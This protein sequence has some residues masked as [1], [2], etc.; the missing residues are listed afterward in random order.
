MYKNETDKPP[1]AKMGTKPMNDAGCND[2]KKQASDQAFGQAGMRGTK[3]DHSKIMS[4]HF[5]GA[6]ADDSSGRE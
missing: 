1:M 6:Y 2:F 5:T 3:A 4:Q